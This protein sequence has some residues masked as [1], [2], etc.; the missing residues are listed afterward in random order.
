MTVENRVPASALAVYAHPDDPEISA[1][2]TLAGWADSGSDVWVLITTRG[3][4]G[5]QD[6]HADQD[7]LARVRID[8]TAKAAALLGFAGH[9]HLD[10]SDGELA[11]DFELRGTIARYVRELRPEVVLCPD[12]TAVFFGDRYFNHRDHRITGWA[13]LDAVAPAAGNPHYFADQLREGLEVHEIQAVYLSGTLEPNC[14]IDIT[15][16]MERKIDALFCHESQLEETGE[17]FRQ[18]LRER[19]EEAGRAA[20]VQ[21]AEG[22]RRLSFTG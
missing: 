12:P 15:P 9:H 7:E 2:G 4:K 20:G 3:D 11:D 6:P 10:Y 17:W 14:W 1:G 5:V 22:F 19:A 13:T 21:Y 18:F 8:E 16:T